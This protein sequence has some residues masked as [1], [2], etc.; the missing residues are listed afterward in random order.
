[1]ISPEPP[2]KEECSVRKIFILLLCALTAG[3]LLVGCGKKKS[4]GVWIIAVDN[5][6]APFSCAD[7][8]GGLTGLDVELLS[9]IAADQGFSFELKGS[10]WN[11]A[12]GAF[13]SHQAQVLMGSITATQE[14]ADEGWHFSDSYFDGVTQ[15][16]A[17]EPGSDTNTLNDLAG[18]GVA[19][20]S[21]SLGAA[22]AESLKDEYGFSIATFNDSHSMYNAVLSGRLAACFEDTLAL[23]QSIESGV[24]L[25]IV[26]ESESSPVGY[27]V[28]VRDEENLP[29]LELFNRGLAN[30]RANGAYDEMVSKYIQ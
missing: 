25:E 14:R 1:M 26:E 2:D 29:F 5:D 6:F 22:Y 4:D 10:D 27:S 20:V 17:M 7:E 28:C 3:L 9:A 15:S 23:R 12:V 30:I 16:M 11:G 18:K 8:S 13:T 24:A 19:V 21:G